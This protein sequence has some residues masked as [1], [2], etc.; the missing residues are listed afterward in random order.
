VQQRQG[1]RPIPAL[2]RWSVDP[3]DT[4]P[5]A[6][7]NPGDN[8]VRVPHVA[9][10]ELVSTPHGPWYGW[11]SLEYPSGDFDIMSDP[12]RASD[13]LIDVGDPAISPAPNLIAEDPESAEPSHP[14]GTLRHHTSPLAMQIRDR[15]L[16][17]HEVT[18]WRG[19]DERRMVE[20]T[21]GTTGNESQRSLKELPADP[22]DVRS[23]AQ[24]HPVQVD[25]PLAPERRFRVATGSASSL[26]HR[27]YCP[28]GV[29]H[30]TSRGRTERCRAARGQRYP[31]CRLGPKAVL[32]RRTRRCP[33]RRC[34]G[35]SVQL[36]PCRIDA[37]PDHRRV[38]AQGHMQFGRARS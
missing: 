2:D 34:A 27:T 37:G 19:D 35:A 13:R 21:P 28:P 3:Y 9:R 32:T 38:R 7:Q 29:H 22:D 17:N 33:T 16:L 25:S 6:C 12:D 30:S 20:I 24:R 26:I 5:T 1:P 14:D 18:F 11:Q 8:P 31:R 36:S 15:R 4:C 23:G 10:A